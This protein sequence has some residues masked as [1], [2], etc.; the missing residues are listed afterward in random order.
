MND[1]KKAARTALK[2]KAVANL[3]LYVYIPSFQLAATPA[4]PVNIPGNCLDT[5]G[6]VMSPAST[7]SSVVVVDPELFTL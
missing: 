4:A 1:K 5:G 3:A 6:I 7:G 2:R